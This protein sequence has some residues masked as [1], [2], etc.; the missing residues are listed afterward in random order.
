[1]VLSEPVVDENGLIRVGVQPRPK[2]IPRRFAT[3]EGGL[4]LLHRRLDQIHL[5]DSKFFKGGPIILA[6]FKDNVEAHM[7]TTLHGDENTVSILCG[8]TGI[9]LSWS[10]GPSS[11]SFEA[12]Y[13]FRDTQHGIGYHIGPNVVTI[14]SALNFAKGKSGPLCLPVAAAWMN[15]IEDGTIE[16][17]VRRGR[18]SWAFNA[19]TNVATIGRRFGLSLDHAPQIDVWD[20]VSLQ[21]KRSMLE[22]LRTGRPD[23]AL[24]ERVGQLRGGVDVFTDR[25][26]RH[27][28]PSRHTMLRGE[29][30]YDTLVRICEHYGLTR[31]E[32]EFFLTIPSSS[33]GIY[34][35]FYPFHVWSRRQACEIG[36]D[37]NNL[38]DYAVD[39]VGTLRD[40]CN[41]SAEDAG[42]GEKELGSMTFL[43][44]ITAYFATKI[45][46]LK[47]KFPAEVVLERYTYDRWD[48]P[49]VPWSFHPFRASVCKDQDHGI[50]MKFGFVDP[51]D[52]ELDPIRHMDLTKSTVRIDSWF[53]NRSMRDYSIADWDGIRDMI[54]LTP[55]DH[56]LWAVDRALG[57]AVLDGVHDQAVQPRPIAPPA[58]ADP[59][60]LA[61]L[62]LWFAVDSEWH[63]P[64][65]DQCNVDFCSIGLLVRHY[66]SNHGQDSA[67]DQMVDEEIYDCRIKCAAADCD[68]TFARKD[69]M[70]NHFDR[71]HVPAACDKCG[72]MLPSKIALDQHDRKAHPPDTQPCNK[73]DKVFGSL[74]DLQKHKKEAH[75]APT[76]DCKE[77]D[78]AF[79]TKTDLRR[80]MKDD[81]PDVEFDLGE[82]FPCD[83]SDECNE[84]F[85]CKGDLRLHKQ[86]AHSGK[87]MFS[88]PVCGIQ[89]GRMPG[90][91]HHV[92][93]KHPEYV[94]S[95][96]E[97]GETFETYG[98]Q[99]AHVQRGH[100]L[101]FR[102]GECGEGY[103]KK[104]SLDDHIY[105]KHRKSS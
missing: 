5:K 60:P 22:V 35:V 73:C 49:I 90:I 51:G 75:P 14:A 71:N 46:A 42:H 25:I 32:F 26:E 61:S 17:D 53:T 92:K 82:L 77:C 47:Q 45:V 78:G 50:A 1:M 43:W 84:V 79:A 8:F 55:L 93:E 28:A 16:D 19:M 68:K 39:A 86:R 2:E 104:R 27:K 63:Q 65:C 91:A 20:R 66:Q 80:H 13:A 18:L 44:W 95:C 21:D 30:L 98:A 74:S 88:C 57:D 4:R 76:H 105:R 40:Y 34:R 103:A 52:E 37:W 101:P 97:C 24:N 96:D 12:P 31:E 62:D 38:F 67:E 69:S 64:R 9:R 23:E 36:W 59:M 33:N 41:K 15:A 10:D 72:E 6:G 100:D 99:A 48:I 83:G 87:E 70:K 56:M 7:K 54:R 81:H 11:F 58:L 94:W 102:C 3:R 89:R 85:V 29:S